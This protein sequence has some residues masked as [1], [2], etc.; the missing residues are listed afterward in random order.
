MPE[1]SVLTV[2][3]QEN[4]YNTD[5]FRFRGLFRTVAGGI[6]FVAGIVLL[7]FWSRLFS[8]WRKET[9]WLE[10]LRARYEREV[11]PNTGLLIERRVGAGAMFFRVGVLLSANISI[12][13]Y[14]FLPDWGCVLIV[15]CGCLILG[16]LMQGS[17]MLV[18]VGLSLAAVGVPRT[19]LNVRYLRSFVPKDAAWIPEAYERYFPVCVLSAIEAVLTALFVC[20]LLLCLIRMSVRF[21]QA[22]DAIA[23]VVSRRELTSRYRKA[24]CIMIF[25]MLSAGGKIAET[26]LQP[27]YG[28]VW[29]IQ[30]TLSMVVFVLF[31]GFLN[32]IAESIRVA[33]PATG[34]TG[35]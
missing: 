14:E 10:N 30:F 31:N 9:A 22:G 20:C 24:G 34:R 2:F 33:Y 28:W 29:L 4:V 19:L 3:R 15:L 21:S 35:R 8:A 18:G 6:S 5:F 23:R 11:L 16:K 27:R 25:A 12:M 32:D 1:H 26:L 7:V 13:Y 17:S